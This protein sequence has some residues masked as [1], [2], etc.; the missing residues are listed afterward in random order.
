MILVFIIKCLI[1]NNYCYTKISSYLI[2]QGNLTGYI[3]QAG[4]IVEVT[5]S[6]QLPTAEEDDEEDPMLEQY[7]ID[8]LKAWWSNFFSLEL[9]FKLENISNEKFSVIQKTVH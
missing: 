2:I 6:F 3:D 5:N 9:N 4:K 8:Y 1:T 7:C